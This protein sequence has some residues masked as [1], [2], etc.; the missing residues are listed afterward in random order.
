[1]KW[2]FL[3]IV[4]LGSSNSN[5]FVVGDSSWNCGG[6]GTGGTLAK[7]KVKAPIKSGQIDKRATIALRTCCQLDF[8]SRIQKD[9]WV[10]WAALGSPSWVYFLT[11]KRCHE[12]SSS[13]LTAKNPLDWPHG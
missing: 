11:R 7:L 13:F 1:M 4:E 3:F 9:K 2:G 8:H 10:A 6:T 12:P 5:W